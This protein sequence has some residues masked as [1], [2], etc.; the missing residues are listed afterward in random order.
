[1]HFT[2]TNIK[3]AHHSCPETHLQAASK[4][5]ELNMISEEMID[6]RIH[7]PPP[8]IAARFYRPTVNRRKSSAASSRRNSVTSVHSHQ[9]TTRHRGVQSSFIAQH[10]RRNIIIEDRKAR[11]ADRAAHVEKVRLRAAFFKAAP[12]STTNS[13]ERALAVQQARER[14]LAEIVAACAEEVKRAKGIAESMKEKREAD[15]KKLRK[16]MEEKLAEAER[17]REENL[18]R[19]I[20]AKRSR[21]LSHSNKNVFPCIEM[22]EPISVQVAV[23]RIQKQWRIFQRKKA[24]K[25]F[26]AIGLTIQ[27]VQQQSFDDVARLLEQ[28]NIILT[29]ARILR[30]CSIA[31]TAMR[32]IRE[33]ADVKIFLSAYLIVGHPKQTLSTR[34][35][36]EN[37]PQSGRSSVPKEEG[38]KNSQ[39]QD[40]ISKAQD[41]LVSFEEAVRQ[42]SLLNEYTPSIA[43]QS[44]LSE[45]YASFYN[46]F[47]AW[48]ARD[49]EALTDVLVLQ[50]SELEKIWLSVKHSTDE[51]VTDS[52]KDGIRENQIMLMARIKRLAGEKRCKELISKVLREA[53]ASQQAK[54]SVGS[55]PTCKK[56]NESKKNLLNS[57]TKAEKAMAAAF[58]KL[59]PPIQPKKQINS[60]VDNI[61]FAQPIMQENRIITHEIAI[62]REYRIDEKFLTGKSVLMQSAFENMRKDIK[63][64]RSDIWILAM[65]ENVRR[66]LQRL[67]TEGKPMHSSI[68]EWLDHDLIANQLH[69]QT[70]NYDKFFD[71]MG[72]LLSKLCA[73]FRDKEIQEIV[74]EK[75]RD[76]DLVS[77]LEALN[78]ALDVL[79]LDYANFLLQR[80]IPLIISNAAKYET[81]QF[82]HQL[83]ETGGSL[84]LTEAAWRSAQSKVVAETSKRDPENINSPRN[85]PTAETIY[86]KML[87]DVFTTPGDEAE[88]PETLQLDAQRILR[89]RSEVLRIVTCGSILIQCKNL[90]KR[91]IRSPWKVEG[92]RIYVVLEKSKSTE[93]A[94]QGIQAALESSRSMPI[95]IKNH[96]RSLVDRTVSALNSR[97]PELGDAV[98]RLLM[99]RLRG[100][101]F[102][103]ISTRSEKEKI[104]TGGSVSDSLVALGLPEFAQKVGDIIHEMGRVSVVDREAHG[105]WYEQISER[106]I[107]EQ[108]DD[109]EKMD[110]DQS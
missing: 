44:K 11:L 42:L 57:F 54:K 2:S 1:M 52:Y 35:E 25:E 74:Q 40:L 34:S 20:S 94:V 49:A 90:L 43:Q 7:I 3:N 107:I 48:K 102:S 82:M 86:L 21:S 50:F 32:S 61:R 98:L 19:S 110:V 26:V 100:Y 39:I 70:F 12:R 92:T 8:H 88:I 64:G 33:M 101:I 36:I 13:E 30:V 31:N 5:P 51:T 83:A 97:P 63:A 104:R 77:R 45:M 6:N 71:E 28:V 69:N 37:M 73:P 4:N 65:A 99:N 72:L 47:I 109:S 80:Q 108:T 68:G 23:S 55:T 85:R 66:K 103:R 15:G 10:E 62:D 46:A 87:V 84:R 14:N 91:D 76:R 75:F 67:L 79:Q 60:H 93:Q 89:I 17:R 59:S 95:A 96:I 24:A 78:Y 38:T 27:T 58:Q 22:R 106:F 56:P 16:D 81:Y 29:T 41:L 53:H 105:R 9:S 18:K